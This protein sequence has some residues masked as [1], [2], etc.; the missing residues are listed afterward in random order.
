MSSRKRSTPKKVDFG[1]EEIAQILMDMATYWGMDGVEYKRRA[2]EMAAADVK[3]FPD[4]LSDI[5]EHAGV[6]GLTEIPS[7]GEKI[8]KHIGELLTTG[9]LR[10]YKEFKK[11]Y[12]VNLRELLLLE[13]VGPRTIRELWLRL[14]IR[15]LEDLEKA[16]RSGKVRSLPRFGIKSEER[17]ASAIQRLKES[18]S[19]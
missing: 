13:G 9:K 17:I 18:H 8:A 14:K 19:T 1:N 11:K 4:R 12:P 7:V 5:H 3:I 16:C 2:Y 15:N 10:E 6:K